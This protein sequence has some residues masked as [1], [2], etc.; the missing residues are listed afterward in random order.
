MYWFLELF[1]SAA[2]SSVVFC[3]SKSICLHLPKSDVYL[4]ISAGLSSSAWPLPCCATVCDMP[5]GKKLVNCRAHRTF[6]IF[7]LTSQSSIASCSVSKTSFTYVVQYSS[8]FSWEDKF[9]SSYSNMQGGNLCIL[10]SDFY[11]RFFTEGFGLR[12]M[13]K[14]CHT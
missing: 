1:L 4:L 5:L 13:C 14:L 3:S 8:C 10:T 11:I 9:S 2:P 7:D 12:L 6:L